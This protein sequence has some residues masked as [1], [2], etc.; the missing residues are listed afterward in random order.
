MGVALP[1][2]FVERA[3]CKGR[4][5]CECNFSRFRAVFGGDERHVGGDDR[6][7]LG[8]FRVTEF[9]A[10][11]KG[12]FAFDFEGDG[13]DG[14]WYVG[15]GHVLSKEFLYFLDVVQGVEHALIEV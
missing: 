10:V 12:F 9:G 13:F 4:K 6:G 15:L 3:T 8:A 5:G 14:F 2:E 7:A 1:V 11:S